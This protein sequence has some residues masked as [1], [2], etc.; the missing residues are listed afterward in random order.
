MFLSSTTIRL[1][2]AVISCHTAGM[3][4]L[5]LFLF[6]YLSFTVSPYADTNKLTSTGIVAQDNE[7]IMRVESYLNHMKSISADFIQVND[8]GA[9]R[10]GV[11]AIERPG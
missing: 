8:R 1:F 7:D 9:I 5:I 6:A 11:I 4:F 3:R 2:F 10:Y